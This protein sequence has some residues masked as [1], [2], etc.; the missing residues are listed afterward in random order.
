M[1][2]NIRQVIAA[3]MLLL[4]AQLWLIVG[5]GDWGRNYQ[6]ELLGAVLLISLIPAVHRNAASRLDRVRSPSPAAR[7]ITTIVIA[8]L[9]TAYFVLSAKQ[10]GT[11]LVP[12]IHDESS[13]LI[14]TRMLLRGRLWM[15]QHPLA[16]FFDSFHILVRPVYASKYFPGAALLYAPGLAPGLP[17]WLMPV[18]CAG[19]AVGLV[20]RILA[21]LTDGVGGSLAA[22]LMLALASL[23]RVAVLY[24]ATPALLVLVLLGFWAYLRWR[25]ERGPGWAALVGFLF[26]WAAITRPMDALCYT[27]PVGVVMLLDLRSAREPARRWSLVIGTAILAALPL[28]MLQ[29]VTN[30]G[31]TGSWR[32]LPWTYYAVHDDPYDGLGFHTLPP[33]LHPQSPLP[34]KQRFSEEFT[35]GAAIE[36]NSPGL[37]ERTIRYNLPAAARIFL[38]HP[39]LLVLIP[40]GLLAIRTRPRAALYAALP[41]ALIAYTLYTF[42]TPFYLVVAAPA[43]ILGVLLGSEAIATTWPRQRNFTNTLVT[44]AILVL[45][46]TQLPQFNRLADEPIVLTEA[47][48]VAR[49][50]S[51]LPH[52]PAVV[53]FRYTPDANVHEE[54][55]YNTDVAWPDD[56]PVIRAHHL[57]PRNVEIFRYY[58][59]RQPQR[60]FYLYDRATD[61]V[62]PLGTAWELAERASTST[63]R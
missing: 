2:P 6:I 63:Q 49:N 13:Y 20:Y 47:A 42:S 33:D 60:F 36:H 11:E 53:L 31:V 14:Q 17:Y 19:A 5:R 44:G 34:Q 30:K 21:E 9:A 46:I 62:Q 24:V 41:L 39:L 51:N 8:L 32:M 38:P 15:P 3:A 25:R 48:T 23:R 61:T 50:L 58:A 57:G 18:M 28:L 55:V 43:A 16:D 10:Q 22:L 29:L 35:K 7:R 37:L 52:T 1:R 56:A 12:R 40:V 26:S 54:P 45:G 27:V 4:G 59:Q